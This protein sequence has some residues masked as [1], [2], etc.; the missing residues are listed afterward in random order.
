M[1]RIALAGAVLAAAASASVFAQDDASG[2]A[3]ASSG[4][5]LGTSRG[6]IANR[7]Y[8]APMASHVWEDSE[9]Q[10]DDGWGGTLAIGKQLSD[11]FMVEVNGF[12]QEYHVGGPFDSSMKK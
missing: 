3:S 1:K 12:Y 4:P 2:G 11:R 6:A 10:T 5:D 9:R 7:I 8:I